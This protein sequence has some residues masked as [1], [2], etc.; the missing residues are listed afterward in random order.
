MLLELTGDNKV[1]FLPA[2][3]LLNDAWRVA[4]A[5]I[6]KCICAMASVVQNQ[7]IF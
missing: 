6:A 1:Q 7:A 2:R 3:K 4:D 5:K